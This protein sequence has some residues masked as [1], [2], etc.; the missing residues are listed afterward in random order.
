MQ[1]VEFQTRLGADRAIRLPDEL[2]K[3]VPAGKN[4]R[5]LL[6]WEEEPIEYADWTDE[7]WSTMSMMEMAKS[8]TDDEP[9]YGDLLKG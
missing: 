4:V 2:A 9:D 8:Y 7:E 1:A 6:L 5:I 3:R